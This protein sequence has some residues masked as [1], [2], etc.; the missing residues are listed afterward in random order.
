MFLVYM[1]FKRLRGAVLSPA[2]FTLPL[3]KMM[4]SRSMIFEMSFRIKT[5]IKNFEE[6]TLISNVN[7][8]SSEMSLQHS[9]EDTFYITRFR[10]AT[11]HMTTLRGC[12]C[13]EA[14]FTCQ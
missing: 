10:V 1:S 5:V 7:K 9:T 2:M 8:I 6:I 4:Y 3:F 11:T 12:D 14:N 13:F